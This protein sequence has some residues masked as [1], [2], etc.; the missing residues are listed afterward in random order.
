M[1]TGDIFRMY[2]PD[3]GEAN[4]A[5]EIAVRCPF[6]HRRE[7]GTE[8][9]EKVASAHI[10]LS[11]GVFHCKV[12]RGLG[13]FKDGGLS[14]VDFYARINGVSYMDALFMLDA[15]SKAKEHNWT[16]NVDN[17]L[18]SESMMRLVDKLGLTRETVQHLQLGY[19][20][21]GIQF[22]VFVHGE[23][24][25]IRTY[26]PEG[27]PK[28]TGLKGSRPLIFPFDLW[29][30]DTRP[31][32]LCE[33]EKDTAI[34]RQ[35]GFN[36]ITIT[37]GAGSFP[38]VLR[39]FFKGR[40][41]YVTYDCDDAG[42]NGA[43][44]VAYHLHQ[45]ANSV[46]IVDLG[47]EDKEDVWDYFIQYGKTYDDLYQLMQ[48]SPI[49]SPED[50][51]QEKERLYPLVNLWDAPRGE[52]SGSVLSSRV[53]MSGKFDEPM[54]APS[55][56]EWQC[57]KYEPENPV[58]QACRFAEKGT[59]QSHF[60]A[61]TEENSH[62]LLELVDSGLK[63]AQVDANLKKFAGIPKDCPGHKRIVR[64]RKSVI[65]AVLSPD[66]EN[67]FKND[68]LADYKA[69]D[70]VAYILE[71]DNMIDVV[72][73][74]RYRIN[75]KRYAHPL[76]GQ[77]IVLVVHDVEP[78][79]NPVNTFRMTPEIRES[80]KVFQGDPMKKMPEL[81]ERAKSIV[82]PYIRPM[83]V[84]AT[85]LIFHSPLQFY[86][87]G[88]L[89]KKGY[90]EGA[91]IGES[92]TGKSDVATHLIE[93][94][95]LGTFTECKHA[96]VAGLIGGAEKQRSGSYR[97]KWGTIPLN[98]RGLVVLDEFSGIPVEAMATMTAVRSRGVATIE[99]IA[100]GSA[101]ALVRLLWISNP[102]VQSNKQSLPIQMYA[103]GVDILLELFGSDEDIARF[104]FTM[105]IAY[106][107][108]HFVSPLQQPELEPYDRE[109]YRQLLYWV[110][111]R[112]PEQIT[113]ESGVEELIVAR[114]R[115][116]NEV[117][118][119]NIKLFGPEA[120]KKIARLAVATACR[121]FSTDESGENVV[122]K[123]EHV[124]FACAFLEKC[125]NNELFRLKEYVEAQR[126]YTETNE[127]VN[128]IV[129]TMIKQYPSV[130]RLLSQ[131]TETTLYQMQAVSG[132][133]KNQFNQLV[134]RL[135]EYFLI[136][137]DKDK[138]RPSYRLRQA[139]RAAMDINKT[140]YLQPL[141][142]EG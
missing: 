71:Q 125:Y 83:L 113:F 52:Y 135:H 73:G 48:N 15:F 92:R 132:L 82:G 93:W 4:A 114:S 112:R 111:S 115:Y 139:I 35:M 56:V 97:L 130:V 58:C 11:R 75:Y 81:A 78:S 77:R 39:N 20:G 34:A 136:Q 60:W 51:Q 47:L 46:R 90:P 142:T 7:D 101:P 32:L 49:F 67:T 85:D 137:A 13:R 76:Q 16:Q 2:F 53:I 133:E 10:N 44:V 107:K 104:D 84:Y 89:M 25:D 108:D 43:R 98:N 66:A 118:R 3:M 140:T 116:L 94:Y 57:V 109:L 141:G 55:V 131:S 126:A 59:E 120:W 19:A 50:Y 28:V 33:G 14:E 9:M 72:D 79:D 18:S 62:E 45:I 21:D 87:G 65:K 64:A 119:T 105:L 42:R 102:R 61:L 96:T 88:K 134:N 41:V 23:L 37:G 12:C 29:L 95:G 123:E 27:S 100:K 127:S 6:P 91:I 138:I 24:L 74:Q 63:K 86:F 106:D 70:M 99:K 54:E 110:W 124:K 17:L 22:P 80:L 121:T 30:K 31:T 128:K 1:Q 36:A 8:Y 40:D 26:N 103:S 117:Y 68:P 122:V 69:M 38:K 129:A 5:G